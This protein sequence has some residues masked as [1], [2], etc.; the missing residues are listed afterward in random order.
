MADMAKRF[1]IAGPCRPGKHYM[2]PPEARVTEIPPLIEEEGYFVVHAP[3]QTGK[4]TSLRNL[5]RSLTAEGPSGLHHC[6]RRP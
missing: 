5:A 4:T 6:R 1:N 2:L 3:R